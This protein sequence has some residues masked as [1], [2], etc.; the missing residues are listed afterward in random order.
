[1]EV[2]KAEETVEYFSISIGISISEIVVSRDCRLEI[3]VSFVIDIIVCF[4]PHSLVIITFFQHICRCFPQKEIQ[5][6][7]V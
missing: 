3:V 7:T 2:C 4:C 5:F 6:V 1:M